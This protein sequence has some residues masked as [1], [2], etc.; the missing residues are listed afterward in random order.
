MLKFRP[1]FEMPD[2]PTGSW[3]FTGPL[4]AL[5]L[6]GWLFAAMSLTMTKPAD[7]EAPKVE[8]PK[9]GLKIVPEKPKENTMRFRIT[10]AGDNLGIVRIPATIRQLGA[11]EIKGLWWE[12][13]K[14]NPKKNTEFMDFLKGKG[15]EISDEDPITD[16]V[17]D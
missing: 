1:K 5:G 17:V 10:H 3:A 14:E 13:Q 7:P 4:V 15:Y 16:V 12:F 6:L 8:P 11:R 2:G 9:R